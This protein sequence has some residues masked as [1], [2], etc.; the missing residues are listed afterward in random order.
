ME[1]IPQSSD[2]YVGK[3]AWI[4]WSEGRTGEIWSSMNFVIRPFLDYREWTQSRFRATTGFINFGDA[5]SSLMNIDDY[6]RPF[7]SYIGKTI[8]NDIPQIAKN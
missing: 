4:T 8:W 2:E 1:S 3:N 5:H 6:M 7:Y